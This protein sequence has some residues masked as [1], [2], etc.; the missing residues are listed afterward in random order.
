MHIGWKNCQ[1]ACHGQFKGK[2][3]APTIALEAY[4]NCYCFRSLLQLFFMG[5]ALCS[6]SCQY[7]K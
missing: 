2:E 3:K 4:C 5:M 6:W 7:F 1:L